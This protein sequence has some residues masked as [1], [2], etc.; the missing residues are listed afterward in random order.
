MS[1]FAFC[2]FLDLI[3]GFIKFLIEFKLRELLIIVFE[4][5]YNEIANTVFSKKYR[6]TIRMGYFGDGCE[7]VSKIS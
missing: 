1:V 2:T 7:I 3:T 5:H 4:R 6:F